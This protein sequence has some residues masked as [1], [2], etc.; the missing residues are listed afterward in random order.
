MKQR[1]IKQLIAISAL[2]ITLPFATLS[3]AEPGK[4]CSRHDGKHGQHFKHGGAH[5]P[6]YLHA[7]NLT[8]AQQDKIFAIK[9]EQAPVQ[10][11]QQK[12]QREA[13]QAL[14]ALSQAD[15]FDDK[16]AEQLVDQLAKIEK[17][18]VLSRLKTEAKINEVLTA[19]QREKARE[20]KV[21][22]QRSCGKRNDAGENKPTH[23]KQKPAA[24]NQPI[25]G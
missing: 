8:Q 2:A 13:M 11:A 9:H 7:L 20:F 19:E 16:K 1:T 6:H 25:N 5:M 24:M 12:Q 21:H 15:K 18:K 4:S 17:E 23:F 3:Q 10:Y 22:A 14:R